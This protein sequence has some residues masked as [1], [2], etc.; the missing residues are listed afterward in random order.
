MGRRLVGLLRTSSMHSANLSVMARYYRDEHTALVL[1]ALVPV[2]SQGVTE[3]YRLVGP[4]A[5]LTPIVEHVQ[6]LDN[7]EDGP[8]THVMV[9]FEDGTSIEFPF[10]V[11]LTVVWY[12]EQRVVSEAELSEAAPITW[13]TPAEPWG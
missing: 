12:D 1:P 3:G 11:R 7:H 6:W 4:G 13:G 8:D 5:V 2:P 10:D 9:S